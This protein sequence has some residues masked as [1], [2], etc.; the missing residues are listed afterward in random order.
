M[1]TTSYS[2]SRAKYAFD[3]KVLPPRSLAQT[4][5]YG[6]VQEAE[7]SPESDGDPHGVG[8]GVLRRLLQPRDG[9]VVVVEHALRLGQR[10]ARRAGRGQLKD[11]IGLVRRS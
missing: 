6:G 11:V 7:K 1:N 8:E 3:S 2:S 4:H 10:H 9:V 5:E